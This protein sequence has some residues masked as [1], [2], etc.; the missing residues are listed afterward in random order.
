MVSQLL[1]FLAAFA[2]VAP[3]LIK[4]AGAV[5]LLGSAIEALGM[6]LQRFSHP[7]LQAVG[8]FLVR[9]GKVL[10][11]VGVDAPKLI[12][13]ALSWIVKLAQFLKG[14]SNVALLALVV[15]CGLLGLV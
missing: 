8:A 14:L 13:N 10:E 5:G 11:A 7:K 1:A 3:L 6:F 2:A 15:S 12:A 9:V 4:A